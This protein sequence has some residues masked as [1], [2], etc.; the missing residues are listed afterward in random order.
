MAEVFVPLNRFQSVITTL[1]G[2]DDDV[3][4]T[5]IGISTILLSAQITN[6]TE[7]TENITISVNSNKRLAVPNFE[8]VNSTGSFVSASTLLDLNKEFIQQE[9]FAF[10]NFQNNLLETPIPFNRAFIEGNILRDVNAISFDIANNSTLR[11]KKSADAYYDKNGISLIP[12]NQISA[13]INAINYANN[14]AQQIILNNSVTASVNI[15]RLFQNTITQSFNT[16]FEGEEGSGFLI[17]QLY[18]VIRNNIQNPIRVLQPPIEL[19]K[20]VPIPKFDA[21]S[22]VVAGKLVLEEGYGLIFS[23][24]S[25]LS[26]ILSILESANE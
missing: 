11:T 23:G 9:T 19:I 14:L 10:L 20:N 8:G 6:N 7:N 15:D 2:E 13:S 17:E 5:P 4:R 26:V 16:D 25:Q 24:S 22:P 1:T 12:A 3:Y 18:T 21:L